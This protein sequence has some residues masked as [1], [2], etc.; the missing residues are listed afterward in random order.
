[1]FVSR[2][3]QPYNYLRHY[4]VIHFPYVYMTNSK[5]CWFK[6][7]VKVSPCAGCG[8]TMLMDMFYENLECGSKQRIHFNAFM[9]S[10]HNRK[11]SNPI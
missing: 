8:K 7:L 9:I 5:V 10:V 4:G 6:W 1:M 2:V 3:R 11:Y